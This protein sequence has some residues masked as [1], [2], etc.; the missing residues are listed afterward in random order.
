MVR[1]IGPG[2]AGLLGQLGRIARTTEKL[3][4][5]TQSGGVSKRS[6]DPL[7][8]FE[9]EINRYIHRLIVQRILYS[10]VVQSLS[11]M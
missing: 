3:E 4:Q 2:G 6:A 9:I 10:G 8:Y 11:D 7:Q 1:Q 5:D